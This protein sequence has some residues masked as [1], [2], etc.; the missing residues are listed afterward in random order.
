MCLPGIWQHTQEKWLNSFHLL[1]ILSGHGHKH[2][3]ASC[4]STYTVLSQRRLQWLGYV[5]RMADGPYGEH[6]DTHYRTHTYP[7]QKHRKHDVKMAG[8]DMITER[9][10]SVIVVN[11]DQLL[12]RAWEGETTEEGH[13]RL[14]LGNTESRDLPMLQSLHSRLHV[15][16]RWGRDFHARDGHLRPA[17][18]CTSQN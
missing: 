17:R 6:W 4:S 8:I 9:P 1:H 15:Y 10:P 3:C 16:R 11:G 13:N 5:H 12:T 18:R 7:L 14:R 2:K